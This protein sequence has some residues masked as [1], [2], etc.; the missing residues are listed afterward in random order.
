MFDGKFIATL[1]AVAVSVFAICNFNN[2]KI[3]SNEGFG[4]NPSMTWKVQREQAVGNNQFYS[5]PGTY[6][7]M[8]SPRFDP[9]QHGAH[10]K[11]NTPCN[12]KMAA[13]YHPLTYGNMVRENYGESS[14]TSCGSGRENSGAPVIE[15][16]HASGN[17][18][19]VVGDYPDT[20]N[21]LPVQNM[22]T[23][24]TVGENGEPVQAYVIDRLIYANRNSRLR[25]LGDPIRGDLA[26]APNTDSWFRPSV[27]PGIDLQQGAMNVMGGLTN[28][29]A[30]AMAS[31]INKTSGHSTI[32]G[33]D[34]TSR[35]SVASLRSL[36]NPQS[37]S[38][39]QVGA[40]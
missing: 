32:A 29:T 20:N 38:T 6:Q 36:S 15:A 39:L 1:F 27:H 14:A 7:A 5:V 24:N 19:S 9:G 4:M 22:S 10:V 18:N 28:E 26:I 37:M 25:R 35:E 34:M 30:L 13:P 2:K 11:Y 40:Y 8:L 17:Y 3:S 16:N 21:M 31:L 33:V 23:I 12:D